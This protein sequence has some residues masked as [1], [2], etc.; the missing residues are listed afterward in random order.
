MKTLVIGI[1]SLVLCSGCFATT[2]LDDTANWDG[3]DVGTWG[4]PPDTATHGQTFTVESGTR[5]DYF[6]FYMVHDAN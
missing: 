5:L 3:A 1:I 6:T 4:E 2:I